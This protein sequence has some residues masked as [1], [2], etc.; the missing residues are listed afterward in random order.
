MYKAPYIHAASFSEA[1]FS[2]K[3]AYTAKVDQRI[4]DSSLLFIHIAETSQVIPHPTE[5]PL[6]LDVRHDSFITDTNVPRSPQIFRGFK[7]HKV[8]LAM[9]DTRVTQVAVPRLE[10]ENT[11]HMVTY[12]KAW[13]IPEYRMADTIEAPLAVADKDH[14]NILKDPMFPA[15]LADFKDCLLYTSD[16]ADE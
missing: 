11:H 9:E 7:L 14:W 12:Q 6:F 10:G 5:W 15:C 2:L 1:Y 8:F 4:S 13:T 16:A 3:F